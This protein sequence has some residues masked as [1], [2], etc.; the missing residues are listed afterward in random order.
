LTTTQA[1]LEHVLVTQALFV[2][3]VVPSGRGMQTP[4]DP[5]ESHVSHA[6]SQA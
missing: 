5:Y 3:H 1:P 4:G 2:P 6:P